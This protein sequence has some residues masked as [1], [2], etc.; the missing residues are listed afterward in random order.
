MCAA[1]L[2]QAAGEAID[3]DGAECKVEAAS[4]GS[5]SNMSKHSH[6]LFMVSTRADGYEEKQVG[7]CDR[8]RRN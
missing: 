6:R 4:L 8:K 2:R 1:A 5:S 3:G 7:R